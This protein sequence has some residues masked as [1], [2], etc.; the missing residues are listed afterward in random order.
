MKKTMIILLV[1]AGLMLGALAGAFFGVTVQSKIGKA[2]MQAEI[3]A[4]DNEI[5]ARDKELNALNDKLTEAGKNV[6]SLVKI[7]NAKSA[8]IDKKDKTIRELQ[9]QATETLFSNNPAAQEFN[10]V[11]RKQIKQG[12]FSGFEY[13]AKT[14][15]P[16]FIRDFIMQN[17]GLARDDLPKDDADLIEYVTSIFRLV[18]GSQPNPGPKPLIEDIS[19]ALRVNSDNSP[20]SPATAFK[21]SDNRIYACFQNQGALKGR[22]RVVTRWTSKAANEVIGLETK[23]IDPNAP[24]NFIWRERREGWPAGE[25][26]VELFDTKT[27]ALIGQDAFTILPEEKKEAPKEDKPD[28]SKESENPK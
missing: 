10:S 21:A 3:S 7:V 20:I 16:E 2:I 22:A 8:E 13:L 19:F 4:K 11:I 9:K 24:H 15:P 5:N 14:L 1:I 17:L 25:Y 27:L 18:N 23:T 6:D 28:K 12:D 26:T